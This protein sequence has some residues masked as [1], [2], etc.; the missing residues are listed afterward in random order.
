[1][2]AW[3]TRADTSVQRYGTNNCDMA[4]ARVFDTPELLERILLHL[5]L[6]DLLLAQ[7]VRGSWRS[8]IDSSKKAQKALFLEPYSSLVVEDCNQLWYIKNDETSSLAFSPL[9]NPFLHPY[10]DPGHGVG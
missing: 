10:T 8:L 3:Q 2:F 1:M 4:A 9:L 7:R 5:P 6:R